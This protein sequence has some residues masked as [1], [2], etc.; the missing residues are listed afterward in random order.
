VQDAFDER[1]PQLALGDQPLGDGEAPEED[2]WQRLSWA[3]V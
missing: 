1:P 3:T 2:I